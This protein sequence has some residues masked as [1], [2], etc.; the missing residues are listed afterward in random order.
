MRML[1]V[2]VIVSVSLFAGGA[3]TSRR[4]GAPGSVSGEVL[5][6]SGNTFA[7]QGIFIP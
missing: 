7:R 1:S 2:A 5:D 4:D 3:Q 6:G